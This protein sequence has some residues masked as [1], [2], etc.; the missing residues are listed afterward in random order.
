M[1]VMKNQH[2]S[3]CYSPSVCVPGHLSTCYS[4]S[5]CV[6]GHLSTCYSPSVCVPGHLLTG[7][8]LTKEIQTWKIVLPVYILVDI[9][10]VVHLHENI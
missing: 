6:P 3:T 8:L 4:P 7:H 1:A 9:F 5:V 2:L 10:L